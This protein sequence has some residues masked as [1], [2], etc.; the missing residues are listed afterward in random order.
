MS[1]FSTNKFTKNAIC[2]GY[3]NINAR[4]NNIG[5][6][7]LALFILQDQLLERF[8]IYNTNMSFFRISIGEFEK[9][10][11]NNLKNTYYMLL[12]IFFK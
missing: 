8:H 7:L 4:Q 1:L 3:F 10:H 11:K 6:I 5:L 12:R 2:R 9:N